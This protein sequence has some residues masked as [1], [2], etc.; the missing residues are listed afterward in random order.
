MQTL[1][2]V[3]TTNPKQP[4]N[5]DRPESPSTKII[6]YFFGQLNPTIKNFEQRPLLGPKGARCT[7]V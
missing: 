5:K 4:V 3:I 7:Q 6:T 2:Y 1:K